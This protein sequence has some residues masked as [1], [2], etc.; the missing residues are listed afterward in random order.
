MVE[1]KGR[2]GERE[3]GGRGRK[4][5]EEEGGRGGIVKGERGNGEERRGKWEE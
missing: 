5:G 4:G 1:G 3:R 2:E